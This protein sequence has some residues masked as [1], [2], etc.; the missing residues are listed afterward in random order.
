MALTKHWSLWSDDLIL[1]GG[2]GEIGNGLPA[3]V[4]HRQGANHVENQITE[5]RW[6]KLRYSLKIRKAVPK[7]I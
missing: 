7:L 5:D 2:K 1:E 3:F 6:D 4:E